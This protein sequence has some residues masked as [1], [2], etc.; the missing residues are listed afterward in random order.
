MKKKNNTRAA[1][2]N[3]LV[4]LM[5]ISK[6]FMIRPYSPPEVFFDEVPS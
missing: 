4:I 3:F 6:T 5:C 1:Q 2:K